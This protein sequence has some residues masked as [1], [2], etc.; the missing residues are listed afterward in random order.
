MSKTYKTL[1]VIMLCAAFVLSSAAALA[2]ETKQVS[3]PAASEPLV[4]SIAQAVN[5]MQTEGQ[6][7]EL[8][9]IH[10]QEDQATY[11][12][13]SENYDRIK[14]G[15]KEIKTA[16]GTQIPV[17]YTMSQLGLTGANA[18]ER[19]IAAYV[20]N[21]N[22]MA[23]MQGI[24]DARQAGVTVTNKEI[25]L[26][27]RD[28]AKR[29]I[30]SNRQAEL[31]KIEYTTV[32]LYYC[33]LPARDN[34]Q[35]CADNLQAKRTIL[36][37]T[38]AKKAAGMAAGKDVLSAKAE[39]TAAQSKLTE[40]RATLENTKLKFNYLLNYHLMQAVHYQDG[41]K[42]LPFPT[43][44]V[45]EAVAKALANRPEI[46][47]SRLAVEIYKN[48]HSDVNTYPHNSATYLSADAQVKEAENTAQT[49][50]LLIEIDIRSRYNDL[51]ALKDKVAKAK[52]TAQYAAEGYRL[53]MLSYKEGM[54]TLA[55]LQNIQVKLHEA[56]LAVA[57]AIT[58]YNLAV[59]AFNY[60]ST[61]GTER[62]TL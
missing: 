8:A 53:S 19:A 21:V 28:F 1:T 32:Q 10:A 41:L 45:E 43:A 23:I 24:A 13:Y 7:A 42:E 37:N 58:E 5:I 34:A 11:K 44:T 16:Q 2:T 57:A 50:P 52:Q 35:I 38:E 3:E 60:A 55:E 49:A 61:V 31:N 22:N 29:H 15:L 48:L 25:M 62:L 9:A 40:A 51:L 36:K 26:A 4:L 46:D 56:D 54:T 39:L 17:A 47:G 6:A 12:S 33:V 14:R 18:S 20:T 59:Y 27:R 30:E